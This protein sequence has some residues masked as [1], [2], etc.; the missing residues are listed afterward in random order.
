[1]RRGMEDS[2]MVPKILSSGFVISQTNSVFWQIRY[3][4]WTNSQNRVGIGSIDFEFNL[5]ILN[6]SNL[7]LLATRFSHKLP[8]YVFPVL[9]NQAFVIDPFS[10]NWNNIHAYAFPTTILTP[11]VLNKIRQS[12][13]R[14]IFIAP[15][16]PQ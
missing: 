6:H 11:S 10:M 3:R 12:Q 16:W 5:Q 13:C 1:M 8:L 9:D 15:L 2:P 14:L 7:D 4:L